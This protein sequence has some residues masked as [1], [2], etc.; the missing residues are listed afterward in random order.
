MFRRLA[1]PDG[2][3]SVGDGGADLGSVPDDPRVSEEPI[4]IGV[5]EAGD[6]G[7]VERRERPAEADGAQNVAERRENI[8][9]GIRNWAPG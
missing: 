2:G 3:L 4:D 5:G 8:R 6:D 1:E 9:P 7:R